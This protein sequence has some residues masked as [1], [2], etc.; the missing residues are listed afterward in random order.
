MS[1]ELATL[2]NM[3]FVTYSIII[4]QK[5]EKPKKLSHQKGDMKIKCELYVISQID[6]GTEEK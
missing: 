6:S 3:V 5:Q 1:L 2:L 4:H